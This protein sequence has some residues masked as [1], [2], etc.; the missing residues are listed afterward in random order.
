MKNKYRQLLALSTAFALALSIS[1]TSCKKDKDD[2]PKPMSATVNGTSIDFSTV[3]G[4]ATNGMIALEGLKDSSYIII[5]IPDAATVNSTYDF[6][7][8]D[9]YYYDHK[10]NVIYAS[11]T[12]NTHGSVTVS[13]YDKS[14][15]KIAGK[16]DGV[17]YGWTT[18]NDSVVIKNGQFNTTYK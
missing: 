9:M 8:L 18:A 2:D 10:K 3:T 15:K 7:D 11:F 16:F 13:S 5:N 6:E 14:G 4:V 1:V 12:T 17:I